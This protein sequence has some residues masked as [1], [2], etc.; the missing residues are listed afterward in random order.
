ML[1]FSIAKVKILDKMTIRPF[2]NKY[3]LDAEGKSPVS[4]VI[5]YQKVRK[6]FPIGLKLSPAEY[7]RIMNAKR[8]TDQEREIYD[9]INHAI[10]KAKDI[11][12]DLPIF[13]FALFEERF[14]SNKKSSHSVEDAIEAYIEE[15]KSQASR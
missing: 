9:Y 1:L 7:E 5:T 8:R 14:F 13:S 15:L 2:I 10:A 12:K 6:L 3:Y 4:I 11:A